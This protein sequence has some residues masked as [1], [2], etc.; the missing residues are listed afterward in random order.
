MS[1]SRKLSFAVASA[2]ATLISPGGA[3]AA[4]TGL[5]RVASGLSSPMFVTYAPG[6]RSRLFIVERGSGTSTNATAN[7][8]ILN[9][10]TGSVNSTPFLTIPGVNINGEG[11]FLGMAFSPNYQTDH[12][13]YVYVTAGP[14]TTTFTSYIRQYTV[15]LNPDVAN[16]TYNDV[17]NVVQPPQTNH[18]GGWIGFSPNNADNLYI[19]FG[20]GG[21]AG[22]DDS[23]H[24]ATIGNGQDITTNLGKV[25]RIN[26]NGDDFPGDSTKNYAIPAGNPFAGATA[27]NDEIWAY[28]VRNPFRASFDRNTGDLWIGDVGQDA[29]EEIDFQAA[30]KT[31]VSNYG[32]RLWEGNSRYG[33]SPGDPFP[34][35]YVGPVYDY[36]RPGSDPSG[37]P[38]NQYK[39]TVVTGGYVYRGPDPTVQGKYFFLDSRNTSSTS[40]DNYWMA[41][42]NPFSSVTNINSTLTFNT[43]SHQFPDSFGEDAV[44]NLYISYLSSGEIYRLATAHIAGDYDYDGDVDNGDY[45]IWRKTVGLVSTTAPADGNGNGVV[46]AADY[47]LWRKNLGRTLGSGAGS[48]ASVPEPATDLY[49]CQLMALLVF[50]FVGRRRRTRIA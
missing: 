47:V 34:T 6:D 32:W 2:M 28:G 39:G 35:N 14:L 8:K 19:M 49:V 36:G 37:D 48:E 40:D 7:I 5:T 21:G 4:V 29:H 31:T 23:G 25:L 33:A 42:T 45:D 18:K 43:G 44:G 27:G 24:T 50:G 20:D 1:V 41:S 16:T 11:G 22:D 46:D 9:M 15:S 10:V 12:K 30:A 13:F 26:V 17:L 38:T 3:P